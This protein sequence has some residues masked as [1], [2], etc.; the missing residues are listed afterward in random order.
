VYRTF[1]FAIVNPSK[2]YVEVSTESGQLQIVRAHTVRRAA[3]LA[4]IARDGHVYKTDADMATLKRTDGRIEA[5][6]VGINEASTFLGFCQ[7]HDTQ[8]FAPLELE[9][10][11]PTAEQALLLA[12]RPLAKELYLKLRQRETLELG[13]SKFSGGEPQEFAKAALRGAMN[14]IKELRAYKEAFDRQLLA[15]DYSK[16]RRCTVYFDRVPDVM[17]SGIVQP[18][19]TFAG[20]FLQDLADLRSATRF[21][22]LSL[23]ATRSVG[24]AVF[25]WPLEC[26]SVVTPLVNSLL[27]FPRNAIPAAL[28]R[29]AF[30]GLENIFLRP[31]WW[32]GLDATT[33]AALERRMLDNVGTN[34]APHGY[35]RDDGVRPVDWQVTHIEL[36]GRPC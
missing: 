23:L 15:G 12:Y 18:T 2:P 24:A 36:N 21:V 27:E 3:D 34:E 14:A 26:D 1:V 5:I 13:L 6:L 35:L 22:S 19:E 4:R 9:E 20:D 7:G 31:E 16:I 17:C 32:E 28:V 29:Y 25:S 30:S 11:E 10:I 8:T 33:R